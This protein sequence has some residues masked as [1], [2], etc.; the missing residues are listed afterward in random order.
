LDLLARKQ[1]FDSEWRGAA[2]E[3]VKV[4]V[5]VRTEE[6]EGDTIPQK[7]ADCGGIRRGHVSGEGS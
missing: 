1:D 7:S 4:K 2:R 5:K 6:T 3:R